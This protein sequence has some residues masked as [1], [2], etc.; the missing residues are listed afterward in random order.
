MG[1]NFRTPELNFELAANS[2][3]FVRVRRGVVERSNFWAELLK[4]PIKFKIPSNTKCQILNYVGLP[5]NPVNACFCPKFKFDVLVFGFTNSVR[6]QF[7]LHSNLI[8]THSSSVELFFKLD[9]VRRGRVRQNS[10]EFN[11]LLMFFFELLLKFCRTLKQFVEPLSNCC[12]TPTNGEFERVQRISYIHNI[13]ML[14]K[15]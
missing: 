14:Y 5:S 9:K 13:I 12:R 11:E 7:E 3:E 15:S 4:M 2:S 1:P 6:T 10:T 8:R